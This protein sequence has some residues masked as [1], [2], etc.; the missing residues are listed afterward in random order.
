MTVFLLLSA[1]GIGIVAGLRALT[2]PAVTA[3]AAHW[4]WLDL[5]NS[6][7]AFLGTSSAASIL[8]AMALGEL[9]VD[10][11]P[12]T[13]NRTAPF[14]LGARLV[15]GGLCGAA[16]FISAQQSFI[17]GTALGAVGGIA[18]AFC[19]YHARQTLVQKLHLPD[20]AVAL[21]EDFLAVG[22]SLLLLS[23][24]NMPG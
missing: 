24:I 5:S 22:G 6:H 17:V 21:A 18:G 7:L 9:V 13:P 3:W 19:G 14:G 8:S 1:F 20:F 10:K 2:A 11:L 4:G 16:V 15:T 12:S 23:R